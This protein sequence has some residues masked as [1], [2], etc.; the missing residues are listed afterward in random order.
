MTTC[1]L[2][3]DFRQ[4]MDRASLKKPVRLFLCVF[5]GFFNT[6]MYL[7]LYI[8]QLQIFF[9]HFYL[10]LQSL[11]LCSIFLCFSDV[12]YFL[13]PCLLLIIN[14]HPLDPSSSF[15]FF[16]EF[17]SLSLSLSLPLSRTVCSLL[18]FCK[19]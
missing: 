7:C 9:Q 15:P 12:L 4:K 14:P 18:A 10:C 2:G 13:L 8:F 3:N 17:Y 19:L 6:F 11:Y 16:V 1:W 5:L